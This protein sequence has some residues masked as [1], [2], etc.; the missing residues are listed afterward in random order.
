M[1]SKR[2]SEPELRGHAV[3]GLGPKAADLGFRNLA[4]TDRVLALVRWWRYLPSP[5]RG[6]LCIGCRPAANRGR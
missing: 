4:E 3:S 6:K 5:L 2:Q 1:D